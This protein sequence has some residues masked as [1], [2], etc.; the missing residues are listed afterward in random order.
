MVIGMAGFTINDAISKAVLHHMSFGQVILV[1]GIFAFILI[2]AFSW[3]QGAMRP[4]RVLMQ[5][6]VA[7]RVGGEVCGTVMFLAAIVHLPLANIAA[8]M[9]ALPLAITLG[10]AVVLAEPVGWRRWTAIAAGFTGV[11]II[12]RPGAEGFNQFSILAL[13]AVVFYTVRDLATKKIASE[14]PSLFITLLT[15]LMVTLTGA[16]MLLPLGGWSPMSGRDTGLLA[17]AAVLLLVGYHCVIMALRIGELSAVA[18]FR[19]TALLWAIMLGYVAFGEIPD[20]MMIVGASIIV[21][22]GLYAFHRERLRHRQRT[23]GQGVSRLSLD[24]L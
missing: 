21:A 10:A 8:I 4:L 17:L 14:I 19:Y 15:T 7:L 1:R 5:K 2:V 22:S 16:A 23:I 18:P 12:V 24:G 3:Q 11:L 20:T 13:I 9:Q 6:P